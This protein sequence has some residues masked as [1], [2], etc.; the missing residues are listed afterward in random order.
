MTSEILDTSTL[1]LL[2]NT[3]DAVPPEGPKRFKTKRVTGKEASADLY[4]LKSTTRGWKSRLL[5]DADAAENPPPGWSNEPRR[6]GLFGGALLFD[7]F[8]YAC[9]VLLTLPFFILGAAVASVHGKRVDDFELNVLQ[10]ATKAVNISKYFAIPVVLTKFAGIHTFHNN[11]RSRRRAS[12]KGNCH[13]ATRARLH[14]R[15]T[16]ATD[17]ESNSLY[18]YNYADLP[19]SIQL[20]G[21]WPCNDLDTVSIRISIFSKT[22]VHRINV[23]E[24]DPDCAVRR[25]DGI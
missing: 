4:G 24:Y 1:R 8:I 16:G 22:F 15:Y 23:H 25:Y 6:L 9:M 18:Y 7:L 20:L 5:I 11:L 21:P 12:S 2:H 13:L 14:N 3:D 10:E 17:A 19:Q